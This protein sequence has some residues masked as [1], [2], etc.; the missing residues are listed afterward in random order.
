MRILCIGPLW[1]GSNAGGLFK[2]FSRKG[3]LID[4]VDEF[5]HMSM[6]G[7]DTAAKA[8]YKLIRPF[9]AKQYNKDIIDR[10]N[11]FKPQIFFVFKGT[12]VFAETL[13]YAKKMGCK[14]ALFYPDVS[15]TAHG[16]YLSKAIP[17]YDIIFTTK[18]FGEKDLQ[19]QFGISKSYFVPHGFDPEI[20]RKIN[21]AEEERNIFSCDTSFIGTWSPKKEMY[22]STLVE[23]LPGIN[24]KIW[25]TQWEKA[26]NKQLTQALQNQPIFGDMYAMAIQ[27]S[28]I[29]LGI[30]SE[31]VRGASSGDLITSRTFHITGA[32]GFLLHEQNEESVLYYQEGVEAAFFADAG[33]MADKVAYYLAND[34]LRVSIADNGYKKANLLYSLDNRAE[35]ILD[36]IKKERC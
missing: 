15:M 22:L 16:A 24:L 31:Q 30:L 2:A 18:S 12:F 21:I 35:Y 6:N 9:Q 3:C 10:I 34:D 13:A 4:I 7:Q 23:K 36:I 25:G 26:S 32:G 19:A 27:C 14:L 1:R 28:K 29:N 20:H 33:E 5:Y 11:I 8:L 17:Q